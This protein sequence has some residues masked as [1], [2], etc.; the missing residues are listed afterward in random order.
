GL[1]AHEIAGIDR[2]IRQAKAQPF[3]I[4][5]RGAIAIVLADVEDD[6]DETQRLHA[7]DLR[8]RLI[9]AACAVTDIDRMRREGDVFRL[10]HREADRQAALVD[11]VQGAGCIA[12][13]LA[14]ARQLRADRVDPS[15][16]IDPPDGE[17]QGRAA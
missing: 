11:R 5:R 9:D 4:K 3:L 12:L 6:M 1:A 17:A 16:A 2:A 7:L 8:K 10:R 14:V 13:Y 15:F